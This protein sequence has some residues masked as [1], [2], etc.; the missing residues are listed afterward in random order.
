MKRFLNYTL[1]GLLM[2]LVLVT[3]GGFL[4]ISLKTPTNKIQL[5]SSSLANSIKTTAVESKKVEEIK[6][7]KNIEE[8]KEIAEVEPKVE[9][10]K[11]E[12][13]EEVKETPVEVKE[14]APIVEEVIPESTPA[15]TPVPTPIPTPTPTPVPTIPEPSGSYNPNTKLSDDSGVVATY[16]GL[17]TAYGPDCVG[18]GGS[19]ATGYNVRNGNIYYNHPTYGTIRIVAGDKSI[20]RKVVRITGLN[21]SSEPVIA[22][23]LD[24]GG[25]IGFNKPKGIILDLLYSSEKS[26]EVLNFGMQKATVEVLE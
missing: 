16:T 3:G 15:P 14:T 25:D 4:Y 21:I 24:T 20:L 1:K 11:E 19:T 10:V 18:C 2:A 8:K 26:P 5:I 6:E 13:V 17:V 22:I 23:V 9:E 12:K 7:E